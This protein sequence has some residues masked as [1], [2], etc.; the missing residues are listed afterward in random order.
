MPKPGVVPLSSRVVSK[1]TLST[2]P[3]TPAFRS[4]ATA[5]GVGKVVTSKRGGG[6]KGSPKAPK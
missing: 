3:M 1:G 6:D 2:S 4:A 5:A